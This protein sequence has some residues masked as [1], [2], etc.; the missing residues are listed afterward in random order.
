M[1]RQCDV[2]CQQHNLAVLAQP[3]KF[4]YL[5]SSI[6]RCRD[7]A[8]SCSCCSIEDFCRSKELLGLYI[9]S[10]KGGF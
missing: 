2:V 9:I 3:L 1:V 8:G 5:A 7:N 6:L 4:I 10:K